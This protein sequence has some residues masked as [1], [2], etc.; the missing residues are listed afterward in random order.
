MKTKSFTNGKVGLA[1]LVAH[2]DLCIGDFVAVLNEIVELP[3]FL[4]FDALPTAA[5]ELVRVRFCA[6]E[7]GM[8]LKIKAICLPFV[9][10]KSATGIQETLDV[11]RN[12]LVRLNKRYA[13]SVWNGFRK[14]RK[15]IR[16][17]FYR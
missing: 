17:E 8:P 12:Q 15:K 6:S 10:V 16:D 4:W 7:G 5:E 3:S 1:A 2:E 11:R 13:K 9:Y 14:F